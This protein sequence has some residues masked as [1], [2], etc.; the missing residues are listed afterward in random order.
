MKSYFLLTAVG[1]DRPGL[2]D[3]VSE[4][5]AERGLNIETS[6][7]ALLG[8]EFAI[9]L[10][11]SGD[12]E[13]VRR[14]AGDPSPLGRT[15]GLE[16]SVRPTSAPEARAGA[17]AVP[18]RLAT[19]GM[20]HPGIVHDIAKVLHGFQVNIGSLDTWV[21]PAPVSGTPVFTMEANLLVPVAVKVRELRSALERLGDDLNMDIELA[22]RE[23]G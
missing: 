4:V 16:A 12:E 23:R 22:P 3:E 21:E 13:A 15:T 14:L 20:D 1:R 7:M 9:L 19:A 11:G 10:L 5:L 2:V 17:D 18:F 8:G 6:R